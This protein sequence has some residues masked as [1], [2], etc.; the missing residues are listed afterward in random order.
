[1]KL[2]FLSCKTKKSITNSFGVIAFK[3]EVPSITIAFP[4][5]LAGPVLA[6]PVWHTLSTV[7]AGPT[8][9]TDTSV[10]HHAETLQ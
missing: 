3:S 7:R 2:I 10:G 4:R 5:L 9:L 8:I 6:V 1:M